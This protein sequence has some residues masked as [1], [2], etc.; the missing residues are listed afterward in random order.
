M[1][2]L[3]QIHAVVREESKKKKVHDDDGVHR[4]IVECDYKG[5][6]S[7]LD[8]PNRCFIK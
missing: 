3:K 4:L 5:C 7:L 2:N 6:L 8:L 1:Q